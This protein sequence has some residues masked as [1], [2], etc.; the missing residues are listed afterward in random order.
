MVIGSL[1]RSE[2]HMNLT[3][4]LENQMSLIEGKF[5]IKA[6]NVCNQAGQ[7]IVVGNCQ[8]CAKR[9]DSDPRTR[10][11]GL[12]TLTLSTCS[13]KLRG[14]THLQGRLILELHAD[15]TVNEMSIRVA[16]LVIRTSGVWINRG[17]IRAQR[18]TIEPLPRSSRNLL[19]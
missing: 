8:L 1:R 3:G 14:E 15:Q 5:N 7:L 12:G 17:S 10:I 4:T 16:E 19:V 2:M 6:R 13:E 18:Q 9:Y 11:R